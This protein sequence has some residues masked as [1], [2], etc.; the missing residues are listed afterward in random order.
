[1][2]L[3]GSLFTG[4][5]ALSA[6]SQSM[7]MISNN[8]ANVTTVGFKRNDASFESIVTT[9]TRTAKYSPGSVVAL[10]EA[11]IDQQGNL[12]QT[13]SN[14][15]IAISGN[16]FFVVQQDTASFSEIFYTRAGSFAENAEGV[17]VNDAGFTLMGWPL[18]QEGNLPA[19][20]AD[21]SSLEPVDVAFL[22][23]LTRPT[24]AAE[25]ALNL[26]A[27]ESQ[28]TWDPVQ[29]VSPTEVPDFSRGLRV[30]DSLG[31][32]QDLTLNFIHHQA[33]TARMEPDVSQGFDLTT[34]SG[35]ALLG[36]T[37]PGMALTDTFEIQVGGDP[38]VPLS[39]NIGS[40]DTAGL[41]SALNGMVDGNNDRILNA[42]VNDAGQ[43]VLTAIQPGDDIDVTETSGT[44]LEALGMADFLPVS[45][46]SFTASAPVGPTMLGGL[47]LNDNPDNVNGWWQLQILS[48][49]GTELE[50]GS[51]HFDGNGQ[52]DFDQTNIDGDIIVP[53][54]NVNFGNGSDLQDIDFNIARFTQ[55]SGDFN[56]IT[57]NQ[58]GA[59]LGLR[60]GISIDNDGIVFAEF[61]NGARTAIYQIPITT[62]AAPNA[63]TEVTGNVFRETQE[64][65]SFNL[66]QAGQGG[67]GVVESAVLEQSNVDLADEFSKMIVTQ[68]AYSA[69]TK[70][71]NTADEMTAEL[72]RLR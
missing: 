9:A 25:I 2:S 50:R 28:A 32:P 46:G 34:V 60:T 61:S 72:L 54:T 65:G 3:F 47:P 31:Q 51:I 24:S 63:L 27:D 71:I 53:L 59:E 18:D 16:G 68:R 15:D 7:A 5:S 41:L 57:S 64:S 62:F 70:V 1:M 58:N 13:G 8:I 44:P 29:G 17:L 55:F 12:Q 33:P 45:P 52:L 35:G 11:Q 66:R 6:Q 56:V 48:S 26:D 30:Y 14:T 10:Q 42:D 23:G 4:V 20:L 49:D 21:L 19:A 36:N 37:V 38:A 67:A 43:L 40:L 39:I 69:G 22:G